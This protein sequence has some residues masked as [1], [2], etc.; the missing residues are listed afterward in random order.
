MMEGQVMLKGA[1]MNEENYAS[2]AYTHSY[3]FRLRR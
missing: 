1:D 3:P 2:H